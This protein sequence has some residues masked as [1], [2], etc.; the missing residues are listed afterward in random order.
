MTQRADNQP[1][2]DSTLRFE[3][4][5]LAGILE[6]TGALIIVLDAEGRV[7]RLN[8][9]IEKLAGYSILET[10]GRFFWDVFLADAELSGFRV[11][12][13]DLRPEHFPFEFQS[14]L[15]S[16]DGDRLW[17][18]WT[19]TAIAGESGAVEFVV[20]TGVDITA[21]K[22]AE[23]EMERLIAQLQDALA[24]V[25]TLRGLIPIC[26][27]CKKVRNDQGYWT[28]LETYLKQHS[29]AEFSHGLCLDCMRKLYPEVA[30]EVEARLAQSESPPEHP[31]A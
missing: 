2:A 11:L 6:T 23:S 19:T 25:K 30:G 3:R 28:Q 26:S 13:D 12:F 20:A 17:V 16:R 10:V 15:E 14:P 1:T 18:Y 7:L 5:F 4:N 8:R 27:S 31:A 9:A 29:D 21:L 22:Q 24:N